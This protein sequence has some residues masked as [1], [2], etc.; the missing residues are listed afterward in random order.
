MGNRG[1]TILPTESYRH[2]TFT[3]EFI[4]ALTDIYD[5]EL[6]IGLRYGV[7]V[8]DF[9][10][11]LLIQCKG[12]KSVY[13]NPPQKAFLGHGATTLLQ[14]LV[15]HKRWSEG[16]LQIFFSKFSPI[17][18]GL[19]RL[20]PGLIMGYL[21]YCLWAPNCFATLYYVVVPSVYLWRGISLFPEVS[22]SCNINFT[23]IL[24]AESYCFLSKVNR[25]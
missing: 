12:W 15:M 11:G 10:T 23:S 1:Q 8:E 5:Y 14:S 17:W 7:P 24:T 9:I 25:L 21:T 18:Y 6:Q 13:Y 2:Y 20:R 3:E 4:P 19:G 16:D 22:L